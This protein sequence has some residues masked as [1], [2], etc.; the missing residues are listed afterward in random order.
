[1]ASIDAW[2]AAQDDTPGR[3]ETIRRLVEVGL[4]VAPRKRGAHKG[5]A[6]AKAMASEQI[7]RMGDAATSPEERQGRKRHLLKGPS[8]FREMRTDMPKRRAGR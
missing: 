2:S 1:M 3:S 7:D 5:A 4:T 8:E 6:K